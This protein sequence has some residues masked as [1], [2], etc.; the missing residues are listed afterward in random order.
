[1]EYGVTLPDVADAEDSG[2]RTIEIQT[3]S[4]Q[5]V[6]S[7]EPFYQAGIILD[8]TPPTEPEVALNE[9]RIYSEPSGQSEF[10]AVDSNGVYRVR[11]SNDDDCT[12]P[13]EPC[14]DAASPFCDTDL[15]SA[16]FEYT[17]SRD[18]DGREDIYVCFW[19]QP[20][21]YRSPLWRP[22]FSTGKPPLCEA[23]QLKT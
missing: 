15:Y 19:T 14:E 11:L 13:N 8:Q 20:E 21:M 7:S 4:V 12:Q 9:G 23:S 16:N 18:V 10:S 17:L 22:L 6:E 3:K 1:M 2:E 5:G